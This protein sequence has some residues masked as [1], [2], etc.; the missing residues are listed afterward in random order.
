LQVAIEDFELVSVLGRGMAGK[1]VLAKLK[2]TGK[3]YAIKIIRKDAII[4]R[5]VRPGMMRLL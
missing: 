2:E 3:L 1:V 5:Q 4:R